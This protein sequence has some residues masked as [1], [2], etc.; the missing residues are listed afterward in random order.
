MLPQVK[1]ELEQRYGFRVQDSWLSECLEY[2]TGGGG[3]GGEGPVSDLVF[4]QLLLTD[5]QSSPMD[6]I[7]AGGNEVSAST[8]STQ[9]ASP[10]V[11]LQVLKARNVGCSL[12]SQYQTLNSSNA[13]N[14]ELFSDEQEPVASAAP[15]SSSTSTNAVVNSKTRCLW[16]LVSDGKAVFNAIE[17]SPIPTIPDH[18]P[19]GFKLSYTHNNNQPSIFSLPSSSS[20][21]GGRGRGRGRGKI[22]ASGDSGSD[23]KLP[24]LILHPGN[25]RG[26]GGDVETAVPK[27]G[28]DS[29]LDDIRGFLGIVEKEPP[30]VQPLLMP[31]TPAV[32]NYSNSIQRSNANS[33][34][35]IPNGNSNINDIANANANLLDDD[36]DDDDGIDWNLITSTPQ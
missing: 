18:P 22:V 24:Y 13:R 15:S 17:K 7:L 8:H 16:L 3:G 32:P 36:D 30:S 27:T 5:L 19:I 9:R 26:L 20:S 10:N 31:S 28:R 2:V 1:R 4:E 33:T 14:I 35:T 29:A 23:R 21:S 11:M 34:N 6:E 12:Y 25:C